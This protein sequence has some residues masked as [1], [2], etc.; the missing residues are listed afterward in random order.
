ML[1]ALTEGY[2]R[3]AKTKRVLQH[4]VENDVD[5]D[6]KA[7]D[8]IKRCKYFT[9]DERGIIKNMQRDLQV[10]AIRGTTLIRV[11]MKAGKPS[12]QA[13][14]VNAVAEA[15]IAVAQK[16][17]QME[18]LARM[19]YLD[20]RYKELV[21]EKVSNQKNISDIRGMSEVQFMIARHTQL[22]NSMATLVNSLTSLKIQKARAETALEVFKES[23]KSGAPAKSLEIRSEI[24]KDPG[25]VELRAAILQSKITLLGDEDNRQLIVIQKKLEAMLAGRQQKAASEAIGL[26]L[27]KLAGEVTSISET[28]LATGNHYNELAQ[29]LRDLGSSLARIKK[30]QSRIAAIDQ[31]ISEV[32]AKRLELRIQRDE[33][34]LS[35]MAPA[36]IR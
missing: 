6:G 3:F 31:Q 22:E 5:F 15:L 2:A 12:E 9:D 25:I 28:L 11:S 26:K 36:E 24:A 34:P 32:N 13:V 8:R 29:S 27:N 30:I 4:S 19:K 33:S 10:T 14:I 35:L 16:M 7:L 1:E 20:E 23:Q 17:N 18:I 21:N